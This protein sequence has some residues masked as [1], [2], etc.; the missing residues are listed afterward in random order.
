MNTGIRILSEF[1]YN[2]RQIEYMAFTIALGK[3]TPPIYSEIK[4]IAKTNI[5]RLPSLMPLSQ[6]ANI[7]SVHS[8]INN[9]KL[10][11]VIKFFFIKTTLFPNCLKL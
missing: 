10:M 2:L 8:V 9:V 1:L 5:I 4:I 6:M 3:I 11:T 7:L